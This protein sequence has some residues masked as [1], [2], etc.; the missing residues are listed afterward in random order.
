MMLAIWTILTAG[1]LAGLFALCV[2]LAVVGVRAIERAFGR[3]ERAA[4]P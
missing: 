2:A 3:Q 1:A 4:A